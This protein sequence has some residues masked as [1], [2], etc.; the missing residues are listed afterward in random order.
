MGCLLL[1]RPVG[2]ALPPNCILQAITCLHQPLLIWCSTGPGSCQ[3]LRLAAGV[4]IY[5]NSQLRVIR[6]DARLQPAWI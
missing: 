4:G 1:P 3:A 2:P 5:V 6:S